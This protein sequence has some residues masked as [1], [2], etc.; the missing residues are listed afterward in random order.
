MKKA[1]KWLL[2]I[3]AVVWVMNDPTGAAALVH[4]AIGEVE[5][6]ARTLSTLTAGISGH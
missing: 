4:W 6:M 5:S 2:I 3:I 1:V